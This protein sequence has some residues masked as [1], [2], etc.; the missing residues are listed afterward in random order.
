MFFR[1]FPSISYNV[2]NYNAF[3]TDISVAFLH[4]RLLLSNPYSFR[5]YTIQEGES[6]E[7]VSFKIYG[8]VRFHWVVL[9]LNHI[10]DPMTDWYMSSDLL[11]NFTEAKYPE[12][13]PDY[14]RRWGVYGINHYR[15]YYDE[16]DSNKYFL[17]DE[18]DEY[19][20]RYRGGRHYKKTDQIIIADSD[21]GDRGEAYING[22]DDL[23]AITDIV[24]T[25]RGGGYKTPPT[26]NI[27][28]ENGSGLI[29]EFI[30]D[31]SEELQSF[32]ILPIGEQIFPITNLHYEM[33]KN[34]DRRE[35]LL[36][37][38]EYVGIFEKELYNIMSNN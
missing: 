4:K 1:Y 8:T 15:H 21:Y 19:K 27:I 32:R 20:W 12:K 6:P 36:I 5:H 31:T 18:I 7:A 25:N 28:S 29:G 23:G 13:M 9:L 2:D 33:E 11:L 3:I 35:I 37:T 10:I 14:D 30:L 17:L 24:I 38:P 26:F 16:K 34:I 22:I